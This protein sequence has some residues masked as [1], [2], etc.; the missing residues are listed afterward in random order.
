M[1][2]RILLVFLLLII[3]GLIYG[4]FT[5]YPQLSIANGYAA[6]K[7]CSCTFIAERSQESIQS[8]DLAFGPL[9]QTKTTINRDARSVTTTL[10]GLSPRTAVY[11][12]DAGCILLDGMDDYGI[13]LLVDRPLPSDTTFWPLGENIEYTSIPP[14]IDMTQLNKAIHSAFDPSMG[15]DSLKTRAVIVVYKN[16][17]IA[18]QYA[19]GFDSQTEILGWSM[20]KSVTSTLIGMLVKKGVLTLTDKNIFPEWTDD[21]SQI[22]LK[23]M[24]QM[25]S[26]LAFSENYAQISDATNMLF[27]AEDIT[28]IPKNNSLIYPPGTHWSY[29]SGTTN[30]LSGLIRDK[31]GSVD[32]YLRFPYDSLFNRIG[33]NSAV[34]ESDE[35][36]HYIGSSFCYAT[37]RDWAK[38]GLLYLNQGNWNGD[39]LIDTSWVDFVRT[40][41]ANS[42]G[43]YGGQF[44]LNADH[45]AYPDVPEDLYSCNGF[46]G[47]HVFIIPSLDIVV[48][49]MGLSEQPIFNANNFLRDIASC[50]KKG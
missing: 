20:G 2:K 32:A 29:S 22:T 8:E 37:P 48:V 12:G 49:R 46:Q 30:L 11:R 15:M 6:K 10:F 26:G 44:W 41:N 21:R 14:E 13:D 1:I 31:I 40:P 5:Y 18:E 39:Q 28:V 7:M 50:I 34:L 16:Q 38:F 4:Y 9:A 25:Q 45:S 27:K 42:K 17:L 24:L 43:I 23:D 36:G 33:M 47:Q 35:S 19:N 3:A